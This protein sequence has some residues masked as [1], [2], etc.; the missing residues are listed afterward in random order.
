VTSKSTHNIGVVI[1]HAAFA[2]VR[3]VEAKEEIVFVKEVG[4]VVVE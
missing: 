1:V 2:I 3:L 4:H